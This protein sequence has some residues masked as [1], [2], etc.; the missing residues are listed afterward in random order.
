MEQGGIRR[1]VQKI[2]VTAV[3]HHDCGFIRLKAKSFQ[4]ALLQCH[5]LSWLK[6]TVMFLLC[7]LATIML[8][9]KAGEK[10]T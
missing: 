7:L 4:W 5:P 8:T 3:G 9:R 1:W 2:N 10:L 6:M